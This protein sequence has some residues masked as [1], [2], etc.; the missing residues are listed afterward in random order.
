MS[1]HIWISSY[2]VITSCGKEIKSKNK[3]Y[4]N[5]IR[6]SSGN[7]DVCGVVFH[8]DA[9]GSV[10][11]RKV[12]GK[13]C[14]SINANK[15]KKLNASY[16]KYP[17]SLGA[18]HKRHGGIKVDGINAKKVADR[19]NGICQICGD[20][21]ERHLGSHKGWQPKGW[22]IGH[23]IPVSLGGNTDWNNVQC[24]CMD[25]NVTKGASVW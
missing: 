5:K 20:A 4:R 8:W 3:K 22:S 10:K 13:S 2:H 24:E 17:K 14:S 18:R 12:C 16:T 9:N 19:D 7:C 25:C 11:E 6:L 21:V 15:D 23:I 1:E